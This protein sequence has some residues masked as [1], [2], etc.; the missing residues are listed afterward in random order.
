[1][2][3]RSPHWEPMTD[4]DERDLVRL[5]VEAGFDAVG[6]RYEI[7]VTRQRRSAEQARRFLDQRG[8]PTGLTW[9][10]AAAEALGPGADEYLQAYLECRDGQVMTSVQ[11][12]LY[13]T[14]ARTEG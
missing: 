12:V 10:E 11:A 1:M 4:F 7:L 13:L 9:R 8:H 3:A 14:A 5:F 2:R 6:A